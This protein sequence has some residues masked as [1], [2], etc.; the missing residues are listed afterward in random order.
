MSYKIIYIDDTRYFR[1]IYEEAFSKAGIEIKTLP[2]ARGDI[3]KE[4]TNY[5]PDLILLDI[6]MP[7][8]TG[9]DAISIIKN[10]QKTKN[11]PVFFFSNIKSPDYIKKGIE[12]GAKKY[13]VKKDYQPE[14]VIKII[15][16]YVQSK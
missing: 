6:C 8:I 2:Y 3:I 9:F 12:L 13:L 15:I 10:D 5:Q 7:G 16:Q 11:I 1:E 4:I 14:E